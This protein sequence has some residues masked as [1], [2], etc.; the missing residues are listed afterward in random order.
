MDGLGD[1]LE[2]VLRDFLGVGFRQ[3]VPAGELEDEVVIE[4]VELAL[5]RF[6]FPVAQA[7]KQRRPGAQG[8]VGIVEGHYHGSL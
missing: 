4:P 2:D 1:A 3:P 7:E 6:V 8:R 5:A